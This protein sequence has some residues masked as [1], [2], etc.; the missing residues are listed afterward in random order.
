MMDRPHCINIF[1]Y[2]LTPVM[3]HVTTV[4]ATDNIIID[5]YLLLGYNANNNYNKMRNECCYIVLEGEVTISFR[6][7]KSQE[8]LLKGDSVVIPENVK[9]RIDSASSRPPC[10]MLAVQHI[11]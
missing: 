5:R 8:L 6:D 2:T 9:Y 3:Q 11:K 1:D 4:C 7:S 10:L